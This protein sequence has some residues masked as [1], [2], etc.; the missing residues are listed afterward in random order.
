MPL[1]FLLVTVPAL[2]EPDA[3]SVTTL[4]IIEEPEPIVET[5]P[6]ASVTLTVTVAGATGTPHYAWMLDK[7]GKSPIPVGPDAAS[8]TIAP[9]SM[10]DAGI[11]TCEVSDDVDVVVSSPSLLVVTPGISVGGS[12]GLAALSSA[13]A[14]AAL[15]LMRRARP[16]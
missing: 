7:G 3:A 2:A 1:L 13:L 15:G 12:L 6:E 16:V 9:V 5:Q 11:Y 10:D 4:T 8:L 14:L